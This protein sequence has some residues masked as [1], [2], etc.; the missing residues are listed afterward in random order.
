[1]ASHFQ[2]GSSCSLPYLINVLFAVVYQHNFSEL[3][4]DKVWLRRCLG[5]TNQHGTAWNQTNKT[6]KSYSSPNG[7]WPAVNHFGTTPPPYLIPSN[8]LNVH[9]LEVSDSDEHNGVLII[10]S[11]ESR[12]SISDCITRRTAT[13][14]HQCHGGAE[15]PGLGWFSMLRW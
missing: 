6:F 15:T 9:H 14:S 10:R 12:F 2:P 5:N 7:V 4:R 13:W 3:Q 11:P 1:M 8:V